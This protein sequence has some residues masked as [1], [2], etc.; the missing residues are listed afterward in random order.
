MQEDKKRIRTT[1]AIDSF[2]Y[3][4]LEK[5]G[6]FKHRKISDLVNELLLGYI[7]NESLN[8][9]ETNSKNFIE[10]NISNAINKSLQD[11]V[12]KLN[13]IYASSV[14]NSILLNDFYEKENTDEKMNRIR[15]DAKH[16]YSKLQAKIDYLEP[17]LEIKEKKKENILEDEKK[18]VE[19]K[20]NGEI[21]DLFIDFEELNG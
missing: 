1:V 2:I 21:D 3:D 9:L 17:F 8:Y 4:E 18:A 19:T 16:E 15:K 20:E 11:T 13:H 12:N 7:Q 14:F 10:R 6:I 5:R